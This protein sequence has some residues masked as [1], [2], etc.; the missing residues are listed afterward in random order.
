VCLSPVWA[1]SSFIN[2]L[3]W[4]AVTLPLVPRLFL[5]TSTKKFFNKFLISWEVDIS[6][7][8]KVLLS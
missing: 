5:S 6:E 8:D 2:R 3:V 4:V 1:Q 7:L